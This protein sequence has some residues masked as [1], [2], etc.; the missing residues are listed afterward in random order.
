MS[1]KDALETVLE[2]LINEEADRAADLLH[3][4][5]VE[6]ARDMYEEL[7]D[8]EDIEEEVDESF[9][10]DVKRKFAGDIKS[11]MDEIESDE[12]YDDTEEPAM[13]DVDD[14]DDMGMDDAD[15]MD[16]MGDMGDMGMDIAA[17]EEL[18][19]EA[20]SVDD[21]AL[22]LADLLTQ[23]MQ[24]SSD[25]EVSDD[26][27][28]DQFS[29]DEDE[30]EM[31]GYHESVVEATKLQDQ[32]SDPSMKKETG[33]DSQPSPIARQPRKD[34]GGKPHKTGSDGVGKLASLH[35]QTSKKDDG[36]AKG[37]ID[38]NQKSTPKV[39]NSD[40]MDKSTSSTLNK[41]S[42]QK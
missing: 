5:V 6:K 13:G 12:I 33:A 7:I 8:D 20:A 36:G 41:V 11:D 30:P 9:G 23:F 31:E 35:P 24:L 16:D 3:N 29:S 17:D 39:S 14:M 15:D 1:H 10:G 19:A 2:Y 40:Q 28:S 25:D 26:E 38:V 42:R 34:Y 27:V 32:V 22:Q 18:P 21:L 4:I 37:N